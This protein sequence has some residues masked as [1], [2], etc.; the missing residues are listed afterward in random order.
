MVGKA[1]RGKPKTRFMKQ[2]IEDVEKTTY[3]ALKVPLMD[4]Q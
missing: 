3:K 4:R 1:K 2:I